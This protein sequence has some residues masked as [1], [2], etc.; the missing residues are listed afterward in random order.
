MFIW[1][2]CFTCT[3]SH[4]NMKNGLE[5]PSTAHAHWAKIFSS[6]PADSLEH[7]YEVASLF[8]YTSSKLLASLSS[9][10]FVIV[11][12]LNNPHKQLLTFSDVLLMVDRL[13]NGLLVQDLDNDHRNNVLRTGLLD[14]DLQ[15]NVHPM[16]GL[17]GN[18]L[19]K[20]FLDNGRLRTDILRN[21]FL[22]HVQSISDC[23]I[24]LLYNLPDIFDHNIG[25]RPLLFPICC[26][27]LRYDLLDNCRWKKVLQD[28]DL[29]WSALLQGLL[30]NDLRW[31]ALLKGLQ[32]N[33][34]LMNDLTILLDNGH[35]WNVLP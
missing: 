22:A 3:A 16:K 29:R 31:N 15:K 11:K 13:K 20:N 4:K 19:L 5:V 12:N 14:N 27:F 6:M 1:S 17:L 30:D 18:E 34:H 21:N 10:I 9:N 35:R 24:F 26:S 2:G 23:H 8:A 28:N 33:V 7:I 25:L 32:D